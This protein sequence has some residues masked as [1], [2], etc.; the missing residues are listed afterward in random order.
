M[1]KVGICGDVATQLLT[2][3]VRERLAARDVEAEIFEAPFDQVRRQL[4]T[5]DSELQRFDPQF[6][7]VWQAV[8]RAR[9]RAQSVAERLAGVEAL[10]AATRA[11]VLYVNA[12]DGAGVDS[13][14]VRAFNAGLDALADRLDNLQVVDLA[15]LVSE[16]GRAALFNPMLYY[17]A[18]MALVPEGQ[19]ALASRIA[20]RIAALCGK[21]RKVVVVDLDGTL[22]GGVVGEDGVEGVEIGESPLGRAHADFQRWLKELKNRGVLLAVCSKN[23]LALAE[24]VFAARPEMPLRREDF[25][26]FVANWD[27]KPANIAQIAAA[28]NLGLDS[29]VFL[30]DRKDV[31][32]EVRQALPEVTVP[33][34][35]DDPAEWTAFLGAMDLFETASVASDDAL[36]TDRYREEAARQE[37]RKAFADE[38][39]FLKDLAMRAEVLPLD[40]GTI[41]RV[42]RLTQRTNQ[43]NVLTKRYGEAEL[44]ALAEDPTTVPLVVKLRDRFGDYGIVSVMIGQ[45]QGAALFI[46]TWLMSCRVIG[47]GVEC[48]VFNQFVVRARELGVKT[49]IGRY[50]PTAKNGLVKDLY[51]KFG[52]VAAED[53]NWKLDVDEYRDGQ[54]RS[55]EIALCGDCGP[56]GAR[57]LPG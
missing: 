4:L 50:E 56:R 34:L 16:N 54:S 2:A 24:E 15:S 53:G 25:A 18:S 43:F 38:A 55:N 48:F 13:R 10:C 3:A 40:G 44:K 1:V 37:I 36:R 31:R 9:E 49:I 27:P 45:R 20:S 22:W 41:P 47:R 5:S 23:D 7:V 52:F 51:P 11:T 57:S 32:E 8:E 42:A 14:F 12:A 35:P 33:E 19:Q 30:D 29:L 39:S 21:E 17:T 46:D 26:A 6:V 28:L